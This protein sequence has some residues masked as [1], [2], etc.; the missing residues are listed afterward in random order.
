MHGNMVFSGDS[1]SLPHNKADVY[2][3]AAFN[4]GTIAV[5]IWS[6]TSLYRSLPV[7]FFL[8][9]FFCSS[10]SSSVS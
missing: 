8:L 4:F 6:G 1:I 10:S 7:V 5:S 2:L 3:G 9:F